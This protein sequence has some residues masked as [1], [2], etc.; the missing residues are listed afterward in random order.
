[1]AKLDLHVHSSYS[2]DAKLRPEALVREALRRGLSGVAVTDHG[3]VEGGLEVKRLSPP[4]FIAIPGVE[5]KTLRGELL[6]LFIEE[7]VRSQNPLEVIDKAKEAGGLIVLPHPFD[8]IRRSR[9][10]GDEEL[11]K[12][13]DAIEVLNSRCPLMKLNAKA[14]Q[15][16]RSLGKPFT[17]GSD[18]H[19]AM[20]LGRAWVAVEASSA[21]DVRKA[22]LRRQVKI[23][24]GRAP[25]YVH[26]MSWLV[27]E[28]RR[29][30]KYL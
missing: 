30:A 12:K 4:G 1:M 17:A 24:G 28:G 27:K 3:T 19:F 25:L 20:E 6:I 15:L 8:W 14:Q 29:V 11:V 22:I 23:G 13:V 5:A 21:E 2:I 26:L 9:L 16:A 18:A 7:E 10:R